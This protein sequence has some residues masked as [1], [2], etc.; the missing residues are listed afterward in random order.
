MATIMNNA[1]ASYTSPSDS[2]SRTISSNDLEITYNT[3]SGISLVK[4]ASPT[5]FTVGSI[6]TYTIKITNTSS[7]Y[8]T[9]VRIIDNLGGGNLAYVVSSA[10]LTTSTQT[11]SVTPVATNP[12]TFTLQQLGVGASMTLTYKAQVVF[13]LPTTITEI[14]NSVEGIGYTSSGTVTGFTN[15]TITRN[16]I[17]D[18]EIAKSASASTVVPN[19]SFTYFLTISN[20]ESEEITVSNITDQLPSAFTVTSLKMKVGTASETTLVSSDY[21]LSP[22]KELVVTKVNGSSIT[23]PANGTTVLSITG[24]LS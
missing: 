16:S 7:T 21:T 18:V 9:G 1:T 13:N 3:S 17:S 4:T 2:L 8:F 5:T 19:Q 15:S 20:G 22:S 14:T 12:L 11:Y 24:Y 6:V 23:V 10:K